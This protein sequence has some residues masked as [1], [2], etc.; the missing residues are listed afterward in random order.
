MLHSQK[1]AIRHM[2][3]TLSKKKKNHRGINEEEE[4]QM[5][6]KKYQRQTRTILVNTPSLGLYRNDGHEGSV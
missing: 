5:K 2:R 6:V 4:N 3:T 1:I